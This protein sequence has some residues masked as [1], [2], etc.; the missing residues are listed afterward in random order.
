MRTGSDPGHGTA[1]GHLRHPAVRT[2]G[3]DVRGRTVVEFHGEIDIATTRQSD[4]HL[5]AATARSTPSVLVDLRGV[6]FIDSAGL[7]PICR[8]WRRA[9]DRGGDLTLL[10]TDTRML[11]I[12]RLT[13]VT[14][15]IAVTGSYPRM[16]N[17]PGYQ[18]S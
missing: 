9:V 10:C 16:A 11:T 5:D 8:A 15:A 17:R 14:P 7:G 13:G 1:T 18:A 3:Q 4:Q 2:I 12:L 6:T